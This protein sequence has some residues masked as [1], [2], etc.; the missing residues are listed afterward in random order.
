MLAVVAHKI[1]QREAVVG[2]HEV[3]CSHRAG[4]I[5]DYVLRP[6]H[7]AR[8]FGNRI[9]VVAAGSGRSYVGEPKLAHRVAIAVVPLTEPGRKIAGLPATHADIPGFNNQLGV[10]DYRVSPQCFE[11]VVLG[12][13]VVVLVAGEG[14]REVEAVS[15]YLILARPV[16][17]RI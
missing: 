4:A 14:G 17:Q 7:A 13:K 10:S 12:V 16:A 9:V 6:G 8:K 5:A 3:D 2:G 1:I 11:K 15:V